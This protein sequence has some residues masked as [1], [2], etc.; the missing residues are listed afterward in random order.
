M[1]RRSA[2][3]SINSPAQ[4]ATAPQ[5]AARSGLWRWLGVFSLVGLAFSGLLMFQPWSSNAEPPRNRDAFSADRGGSDPVEKPAAFDGKRA[6]EYLEA[7]CKIGP[8][9]SG[10]TGMKKQQD[11]IEKH[12]TD[13]GAKVTYQK[14]TARQRSVGKPVEMANMVIS[15]YPDRTRRI[16]LCSHYDTR[17]IADQ[18]P[19]PRR[20]HDPFV[21]AN[22]GGSGVA[23]LMEMGHQMKALKSNVGVDFVLFDGEEYVFDKSDTYFFG[24][25]HFGKE[26]AKVRRKITYTGAVLLDMIAGK[27]ATFPV[28][29][30][31]WT[32]A[33]KL[34]K[35][36]WSIAKEQKCGA[37]EEGFSKYAVEDDHIALN[38]AGIPA[39]DIIDFDY[40]HWHRLTDLPKNCSAAP[41]EQVAKVL[42]IW[43][44]RTK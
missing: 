8:R 17:P 12:F 23:F 36:V 22:D 41:M 1:P 33:S 29:Q 42:S 37:F 39:I 2:N 9:M 13:L 27:G 40:P 44:Q 6:M 25:T 19:N 35:E 30:N 43:M 14:F 18:E 21:S 26:Y 15:Y 10:T 28:E 20:W 38:R 7:I 4:T 5:F 34:V 11:L 24:S 31:S 3:Q 32:R 16:I